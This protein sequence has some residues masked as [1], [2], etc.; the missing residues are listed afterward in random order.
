MLRSTRT[1]ARM[2]WYNDGTEYTICF[3]RFGVISCTKAEINENF[4]LIFK[5]PP[6]K[7]NQEIAEKY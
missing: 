3:I 4:N 6:M 7:R 2:W 1:I 5:P